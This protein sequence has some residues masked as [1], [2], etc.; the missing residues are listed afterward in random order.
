MEESFFDIF[1]DIVEDENPTTIDDVFLDVGEPCTFPDLRGVTLPNSTLDILDAPGGF[2][3]F[4]EAECEITNPS[5]EPIGGF[6]GLFGTTTIDDN[7]D[8]PK[9][10]VPMGN[11]PP[12]PGVPIGIFPSF[13]GISFQILPGEGMDLRCHNEMPTILGT[14]ENDMLMGTSEADI[15]HGLGGN[16]TIN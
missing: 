1:F 2:E 3:N 13:H 8:V 4:V 5:D 12:A 10:A 6:V 16:D 15:I 11:A 7:G 9:A 14:N